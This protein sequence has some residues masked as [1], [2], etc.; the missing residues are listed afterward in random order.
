MVTLV[1]DELL[2]L[3][4]VKDILKVHIETVRTW[5]RQKKLP[6]IKISPRDYRVRRSALNKFLE[7]RET[8][9]NP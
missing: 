7:E 6:A 3:E 8:T 2:S 9:D 5:V 1:E 4:E